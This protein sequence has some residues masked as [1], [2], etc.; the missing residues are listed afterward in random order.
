MLLA[1]LRGVVR[2]SARKAGHGQICMWCIHRPAHADCFHCAVFWE[3]LVL[4]AF[5]VLGIYWHVGH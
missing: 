5:V 2:M 4:V 1:H 3:C